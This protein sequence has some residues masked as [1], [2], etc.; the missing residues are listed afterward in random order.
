MK[1]TAPG[2][3][4]PQT[5]GGAD[6]KEPTNLSPPL[7]DALERAVKAIKAHPELASTPWVSMTEDGLW[8][9]PWILGAPITAL[10]TWHDAMT[11]VTREVSAVEGGGYSLICIKGTLDDIP[12]T[13]QITTI[14]DLSGTRTGISEGDLRYHARQEEPY[15]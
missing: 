14:Q 1:N 4:K 10:L 13:A 12:V 2:R 8:V 11:D 15:E 3:P 5:G 9:T 7:Y 6:R